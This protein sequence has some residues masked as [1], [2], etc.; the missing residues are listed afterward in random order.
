MKFGVAGLPALLTLLLGPDTPPPS[1]HT[2]TVVA[3]LTPYFVS[4]CDNDNNSHSTLSTHRGRHWPT[5]ARLAPAPDPGPRPGQFPAHCAATSRSSDFGTREEAASAVIQTSHPWL[6]VS[7][8]SLTLEL[9]NQS[10][11]QQS[12]RPS[13][14]PLMAASRFLS[15]L[16]QVAPV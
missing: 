13:C 6:C 4:A 8:S 15:S 1:P 7:L 3:I 5:G 10:H 16:S 14:W 2:I 12:L 11:L 9:Q